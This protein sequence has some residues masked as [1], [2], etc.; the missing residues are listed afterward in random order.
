MASSSTIHTEVYK[1]RRID[2]YKL[3]RKGK[4]VVYH[5]AARSQVAHDMVPVKTLT[6]EIAEFAYISE[7]VEA[8]KAYIDT[9]TVRA[10]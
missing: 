8:A 10:M 3:K 5:A 6:G 4:D 2:V 9:H 7:A 1:N